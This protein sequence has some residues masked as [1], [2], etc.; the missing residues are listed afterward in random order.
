MTK[1]IIFESFFKKNL[2]TTKNENILIDLRFL[3]GVR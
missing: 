1:E 3:R 2:N